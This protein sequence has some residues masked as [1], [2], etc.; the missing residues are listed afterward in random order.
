[1]AYVKTV[2]ET[3]DVITA[4]KL[5]NME[6]GIEDNCPVILE[7][8]GEYV[9]DNANLQYTVDATYE[10]FQNLLISGVPVTL[11]CVVEG[12]HDYYAP[13]VAFSPVA[14]FSASGPTIVFYEHFA[15]DWISIVIPEGDATDP[16][17]FLVPMS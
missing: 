4:A 15:G 7:S 9:D 10:E 14:D 8:V 5:N 1:M 3:G 11:K 17:V 16:V 12:E 2:W 6:K 13:V